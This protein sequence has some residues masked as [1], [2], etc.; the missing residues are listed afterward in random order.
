MDSGQSIKTLKDKKKKKK[1]YTLTLLVSVLICP[2]LF[3]PVENASY[4]GYG[5]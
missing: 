4:I 5:G 2:G 3:N 1:K